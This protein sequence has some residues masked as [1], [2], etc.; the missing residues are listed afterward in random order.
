LHD[1]A[2]RQKITSS[3]RY[4]G[5]ARLWHKSHFAERD[6]KLWDIAYYAE[7]LKEQKPTKYLTKQLSSLLP[8]RLCLKGLFESSGHF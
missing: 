1:L 3:A 5:I 6:S 7:K 2:K 4:G 8:K